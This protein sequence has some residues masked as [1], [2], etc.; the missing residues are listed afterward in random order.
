MSSIFLNSSYSK[1]VKEYSYSKLISY[2]KTNRSYYGYYEWTNRYYQ[3]TDEYYE[4]IDGYY[5]WS[6]E[7]T[8][9]YCE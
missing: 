6:N 5:E 4:W 8:D 7:W 3:Q 9:A 1:L 2:K